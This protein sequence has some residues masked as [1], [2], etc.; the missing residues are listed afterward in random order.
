M[1]I[2]AFAELATLLVP[3]W[4]VQAVEDVRF[5][6][7]FKFY[8]DEPRRARSRRCFAPDGDGLVAEC[9]LAGQP[10][11]ARA[12]RAAGD[13]ALHGARP[14]RPH[15][16][17]GRAPRPAAAA[18]GIGVAADDIYRIYFHG[19][20]YRVLERV[21]RDGDRVVGLMADPLP[22]DHLPAECPTRL[23]PRL[24]ELCFQTAGIAEIARTGRMGLPERIDRVVPGSSDEAAE[25]ASLRR[26]DTRTPTAASTRTWWTA[27]ATCTSRCAAT[28][29]SSCRHPSPPSRSPR[30]RPSPDERGRGARFPAHRHRQ[31]RRGRHAPHPRRARAEPR[32]RHR[33]CARSRSSPSPTAARCS[34]ARRT[35]CTT[36]ARR[37][38]TA[39]RAGTPTYVDLARLERAL[40]DTSADAAWVGWGFVA[41]QPAFAELCARL[42]IVF[43]GPRPAMMRLLGDKIAAKQ[44]AERAGVPVVPWSGGAVHTPGR[45][46]SRR[47]RALGFPLL[48]KATAG[49]GGRGIRE[50]HDEAELRAAFESRRAEAAKAFGDG[51]LFLERL[52][53]GRPAR[54]GAGD[55]RPPRDDVGARRAR[56]HH[57]APPSEG[58]RGGALAGALGAPR[59]PRCARRPSGS[60]RP[61]ATRAPVPSSS[62]STRP[63]GPPSSWR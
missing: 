26:R 48:V 34:C 29:R 16:T 15:G 59:T 6:A 13:D 20:A 14:T 21:W 18:D 27:P 33:R 51:T 54:R 62:S 46:R 39:R 35:R 19:P 63:A 38:A 9:R 45:K 47:P 7:P 53:R 37:C 56:L 60:C 1:G 30:S 49:G 22:P 11:A 3:G 42:G 31:S 44:L 5:L 25:A 2:E 36:S 24:I 23:A 41:E 58:A 17:A 32:A 57:P 52:R 12:G 8:R 61:R 55:R 40:R 43:I 28:G 50:V 10:N 4:H